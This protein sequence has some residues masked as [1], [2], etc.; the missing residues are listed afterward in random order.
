MIRN[1]YHVSKTVILITL[2]RA[3]FWLVQ[4]DFEMRFMMFW[5]FSQQMM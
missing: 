2:E 4:F 3:L 1:K 5:I